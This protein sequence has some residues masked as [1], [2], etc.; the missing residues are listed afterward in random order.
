M[1]YHSALRQYQNV[2][3]K[4][5]VTEADPHTLVRMLFDGALERLSIARGAMERGDAARKGEAISRAVAIIDTLRV[6]LDLDAGEEL[7]ANLQALYEYMTS[8]LV[9]ANRSGRTE[10]L[11]EVADLIRELREAW[12]AIP[13]TYRTPAQGGLAPLVQGR[14]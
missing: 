3:V 8:R 5:S 14:A 11:L 13:E 7:A 4:S 6:S 9:E 12:V 2:G 10:L 1:N